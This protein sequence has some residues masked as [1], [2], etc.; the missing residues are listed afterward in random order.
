MNSILQIAVPSPLRQLF[1]YLPPENYDS[2]LLKPGMRVLVN[3]G[4]QQLI[5]L[6]LGISQKSKIAND[7]L[8]NVISVL[9]KEPLLPNSILEL[10]NWTSKYYHH[11]IGDVVVNALP[12]ILRDETY[13]KNIEYNQI[14]TKN[15]ANNPEKPLILNEHQQAAIA[16]IRE[17]LNSFNTFLLNGVTG[18]GKTE[19]YLQ[20][21][22][23]IIQQGKQ[24]LILVPEINL[25]PQTIDRFAKR[26]SVPIAV[27]HSRLTN[28]ERLNSWILAKRGIAQIIIGTRSAIFTPMQQPG[29]IIIDEE[30][31]LSFKQQSGLKYSAR[32]LA[33]VRGKIENIPV[34]L[35]S[36]TPALETL[37]NVKRKN[38]YNLILPER[39]GTAQPPRFHLVDMRSQKLKDGFAPTLLQ[40]IE[41]HLKNEGQILVFLNRRGFAPVLVCHKCGWNASC[42]YC[43]AKLTL[44]QK[45]KQLR[46][47]HCG[48]VK[49]LP[50]KCPE[51]ASNDLLALGV[52][53]ERLEMNLAKLFPET[54]IIRI[55][56]DTT[57]RKDSI[58]Q[59]LNGIWTK[60]YKILVGTQMLAK[61]HHFPDVTMAAILNVDN[62]LFSADFRASERLG[63]LITQVSGRAGRAEKP[64]EVY[65][66]THNPQHPTLVKLLQEG[67]N[68]FATATLQERK[69]SQ[70]PPF[71]HLALIYAESKQPEAALNFLTKLRKFAEEH[72]QK[73][74]RTFG[75]I[76]ATLERKAGY[77]RAQLLFQSATRN[78]LHE[79]TDAVVAHLETEKPE[80][81]I[82]WSLDID[83]METV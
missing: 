79:V 42:K 66:Q 13:K 11:S 44:H 71:A 57:K 65:I 19:I 5:G 77:F 38:F 49:Y 72:S 31:D 76:P 43:D 64:G 40:A 52:G 34:I 16:T 20:I 23:S 53:T 47:H 80:R 46:C 25:T 81:H 58:Q 73:N 75:P 22:Q 6:I 69:M 60:E 83:P 59:M 54:K 37:H 74:I 48:I 18:S 32:D 21:L 35:G 36:A 30:H 17:K 2:V 56:R 63:Q 1:D 4:R 45:Q 78:S 8:K 7:K 9:D 67:Y 62:G 24:A 68:S 61:G 3:F 70:L 39:A 15:T 29:I 14:V 26:F 28:K 41:K 33:N 50:E 51:C 10:I 55:D 82:K 27:L 12:A